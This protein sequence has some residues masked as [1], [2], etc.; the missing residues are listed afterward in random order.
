MPNMKKIHK[1]FFKNHRVEREAR[2][3]GN[4]F[5]EYFRSTCRVEVE[6]CQV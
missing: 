2:S 6:R 4:V 1:Y 5:L 3:I